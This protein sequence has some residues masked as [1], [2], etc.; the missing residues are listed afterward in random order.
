MQGTRL[1]IELLP[2]DTS[3]EK[4]LFNLEFQFRSLLPGLPFELVRKQEFELAPAFEQCAVLSMR[5]ATG[6]DADWS[7]HMAPRRL[8]IMMGGTKRFVSSVTIA[9]SRRRKPAALFLHTMMEE[10]LP[11]E[12][13]QALAA[14]VEQSRVALVTEPL[15][16]HEEASVE[17]YRS[18]IET[19]YMEAFHCGSM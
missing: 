14:L 12:V 11:L 10:E 13:M 9:V 5:Q 19:A 18:A 7:L 6:V 17:A 3:A 16:A 8:V 4:L 15:S 1:T 2:Q